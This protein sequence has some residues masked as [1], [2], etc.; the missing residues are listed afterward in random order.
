VTL[1][2]M[3]VRPPALRGRM[4]FATVRMLAT[5]YDKY[6]AVRLGLTRK[7]EGDVP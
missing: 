3:P 5:E 6:L 7:A 1:Y 4:E 2:P